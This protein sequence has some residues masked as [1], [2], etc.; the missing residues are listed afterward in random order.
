MELLLQMAISGADLT[1]DACG[2]G[3]STSL[4]EAAEMRHILMA[5]V[6]QIQSMVVEQLNS[7]LYSRLADLWNTDEIT[8]EMKPP[9][10]LS[11][12]EK[13]SKDTIDINNA[14]LKA[15]MGVISGQGLAIELGY[16]ELADEERFDKWL[17]S[18]QTN[19]E[20]RNPNDKNTTQQDTKITR[21]TTPKRY[22]RQS[23]TKRR[24]NRGRKLHVDGLTKGV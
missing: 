8:V 23:R 12:S 5:L 17:E 3:F 20:Q 1:P 6:E 16:Q 10:L 2:L 4:H 7:K 22:S 14:G 15:K 18:G 19:Q 13:A 24:D 11:E 9:I 21:G